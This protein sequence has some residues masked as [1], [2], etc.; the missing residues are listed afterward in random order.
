MTVANDR[1]PGGSGGGQPIIA[2]LFATDLVSGLV[3]RL[4]VRPLLDRLAALLLVLTIVGTAGYAMVRPDYNWDMVAY[5]ATALENRIKDPDELHARTWA[6]IEPGA[7][8]AQLYHIQAGNPYNLHQYEN[9]VDFQSQLSMYRVK[10]A[11]VALMRA[12]EPVFGLAMASLL[13]SV[14]PAIGVGLVCLFWLWQRQALQSAVFVAPLL[15]LADFSHMTTAVSPDML[16]S[17]ISIA[18]ILLL[19]KGRELPA[20][21]LLFASVLIRPDNIILIFALLI[22]AAL[23]RWRF[24][25][26]LA[27]FVASFAA[28]I[29]IQKVGGHPGW[30]AHFY[31]SCV[32][33]QNSMIGFAP[34]FALI[35][36]AK[37]YARGVVVSLMDNDW[38]GLLAILTAGW[39]LLAR[40]GKMSPRSNAIV[41]AMIIGALGKFASFPL[42]DDR[43]YFVFIAGL[44]LVLAVQW[45]PDFSLF[46]NSRSQA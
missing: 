9:P 24:L 6:E 23:F 21:L 1:N 44:A 37:G 33:I 17:L 16:L 3:G 31:F 42:P 26:M 32:K 20:Y 39:A 11:Y 30:W 29:Y 36:F 41:F 19:L 43:F 28:C 22:T 25:P 14:L 15:V 34:D 5:V 27:T 40:T 10:V 45:R 46:A 8:V 2:R 35:D 13:L 7:R 12:M 18:A 38:P 4:A